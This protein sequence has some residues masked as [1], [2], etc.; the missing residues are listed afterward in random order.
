MIPATESGSFVNSCLSPVPFAV[1][2]ASVSQQR[3]WFLDQLQGPTA[4]YNVHVGLWLYGA[5]NLN[6]LR[7]S[8]QEIVNRHDTFRTSFA[9]KKS[10]LF[11]LVE[12]HHE[13]ALPVTDFA[14]FPDPYPPAY[15]L[16]KR[17]V[18]TPF[19]LSKG[20]LFRARVLRI[21]PEENVLL[22][23][24]H[25]TITDS[26]STQIFAKE[27]ALVYEAFANGKPAELPELPI[28]YGDFSEWQQEWLQGEMVQRQLD[29]WKE[30]LKDAPPL[31]QLPQDAPR[32]AEQSLDGASQ[33]HAVPGEIVAAVKSLAARHQATPFMVLLACFKVLLYRYSGQPDVL[34]GVPVAGR[35]QIETEGLIGFFVDTLVLRDNLSGDPPFADLLA[36]VR[37]S[38]LAGFANVDVP[39]DKIVETIHPERNLSYSPVFQVMFSVIKSSIRSHAFGNLTAFPYVVNSNVSIF[40]MFCTFIED[41]DEKWW[42]QLD[43]NTSIFRPERIARLFEDYIEVL[44]GITSDAEAHID[45]LALPSLAQAQ[46][47]SDEQAP[48]LLAPDKTAGQQS[49]VAARVTQR[50]LNRLNDAEE[51]L[52]VEI[53]KD[54]LGVPNISIHENFF[55][56]GGHSLLAARVIAQIRDETG[57]KIPVSAIF[58]SPTIQGLAQLLKNDSVSTQDPVLTQLRA[59]TGGAPFFSVA[60]P[61]VD[62]LGLAILA[63]NMGEAQSV[64]KLQGP[65]ALLWDRPFRKDELRALAREYVAAMRTVQPHGPYCFGGMCD[66]VL[67]AQEMILELESQGED[68]GFFAIFDTWVL[69]NSQ[70]RP[71]WA[72]DYY[73][74]RLRTFPKLRLDEQLSAL[75]RM[76]RRLARR[77]RSARSEWPQTYW[78]GENFQPPRF[79]A[80][81]LLFKRPRQPYYYIRD[82]RMGWG[83]RSTGGIEICEVD[84]GHYEM[85]RQPHVRLIADRLTARLQEVNERIKSRGVASPA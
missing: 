52:L 71:L 8:L 16:A 70:I 68:V 47:A 6:A 23:T 40:D 19:D 69:E 2:P 60:A 27:L 24:M 67:I 21:A 34:V 80:P 56:V 18:A 5:L 62:P 73:L 55:D 17:E 66:G 75:R 15:E 74:Y 61:G 12:P 83:E 65:G 26:W 36:Q 81:V 25:H 85:L 3:L 54:V 42:L 46:L 48:R 43:F 64:Y 10:G 29:Y 78:P 37:E 57:R 7:L 50:P 32:P 38:T 14:D 51:A 30:T 28:Q 39:F 44:R 58:R 11:Q 53:W 76:V 35:N 4:A 82:P 72:V 77:N 63:H 41:S 45:Q 31:L 22:C 79:R 1:Y 9:L 20:P 33:T 13:V 59:G 49:L 84:C